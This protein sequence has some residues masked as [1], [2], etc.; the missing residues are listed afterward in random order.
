MY[1]INYLLF[2]N[3]STTS[4]LPGIITFYLLAKVLPIIMVPAQKSSE[5]VLHFTILAPRAL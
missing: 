3:I 2:A 1:I 5:I 4:N